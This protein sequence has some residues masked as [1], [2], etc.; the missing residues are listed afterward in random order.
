MFG[1]NFFSTWEQIRFRSKKV[2]NLEKKTFFADY[3]ILM[4]EVDS[5]FEVE[6]WSQVS[7]NAAKN[8]TRRKRFQNNIQCWATIVGQW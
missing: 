5:I 8:Q 6:K 7:K 1:G 4:K 3:R 2:K